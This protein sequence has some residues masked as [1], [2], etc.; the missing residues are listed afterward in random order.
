MTTQAGQTPVN[1]AYFSDALCVWAYIAQIRL[2]Q[3]RTDFAGQIELECHYISV[4]GDVY[5]KIDREWSERG[6]F[7]GYRQHIEQVCDKYDFISLHPDTWTQTRPRSSLGCHL[8]LKAIEL[9]QHKFTPGPSADA[10]QRTLVEAAAWQ[11]RLAFFHDG[12]DIARSEEQMAIAEQLSLPRTE[13]EQ[14][15]NNGAAHARLSADFALKDQLQISG[16]PTFV[17]NEGRQKLY[18]NVGYR[19]IEANL[20]ELIDTPTADQ[21]SWC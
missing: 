15:L 2:D 5:D 3:M 9:I 17:F 13:I 11:M 16:S 20:H 1:V 7:D 6:G 12:R 21:A 18:G 19:I 10:H 14:V 8:F 4:F